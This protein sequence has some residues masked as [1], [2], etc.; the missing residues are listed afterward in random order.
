MTTPATASSVV[1][2]PGRG[3]P[4]ERLEHARKSYWKTT[5]LALAVC[6]LSSLSVMPLLGSRC[7]EYCWV[8]NGIAVILGLIS[9]AGGVVAVSGVLAL[10]RHRSR[11]RGRP[12]WFLAL[13]ASRA[14][15]ALV[16]EARF[17]LPWRILRRWLGGSSVLVGDHVRIRPWCEIETTLDA[18]GR[19]EGLPFM[20]EM[21]RHCGQS[22]R[23]FRC[24]DKIYDYGGKKDLRRLGDAV[25]LTGLRCDGSAHGSCQ[26]SCYLLWKTQWLAP[27]LSAPT[28]HE[29]PTPAVTAAVL[30]AGDTYSCQFTELVRAS[31]PLDPRDVRQ[32]LRPLVHGNVTLAAFV[33]A[34][35]ARLFNLVQ[36]IRRGTGFPDLLPTGER[37]GAVAR[38]GLV[39]EQKVRV[40]NQHEIEATL[41]SNS[42]NRGL[43]FDRDMLRYSGHTYR[44]RSRVE[45]IIDDATGKMLPMKTACITLDGV[46]ASGEFL[47][48]A[49][50]HDLAYWREAWLADDDGSADHGV[51]PNR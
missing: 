6:L 32:D 48:F 36:S 22:A 15:R 9:V 44:V 43:W 40:L 26:A 29:T 50:Q 30:G 8:A 45:R 16:E 25:L 2:S 19:L 20:D 27:L 17:R 28:A 42:R 38:L 24:V 7:G 31:T 47:R 11:A 10:L 21:R 51:A 34:I 12:D 37:R 3:S 46:D 1:Q 35:L 23:V 5:L 4:S 18:D 33:V 49:S 14:E 39:P 13:N 41:G